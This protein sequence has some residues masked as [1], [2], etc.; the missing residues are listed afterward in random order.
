MKFK[1]KPPE[2]SNYARNHT[3]LHSAEWLLLGALLLVIV[4]SVV[5]LAVVY[6]L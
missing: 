4:T 2:A 1:G 6:A 5:G 3:E